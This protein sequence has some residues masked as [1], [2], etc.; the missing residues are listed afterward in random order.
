M[1]NTQSGLDS[2]PLSAPLHLRISKKKKHYMVAKRFNRNVF[3]AHIFREIKLVSYK[4]GKSPSGWTRYVVAVLPSFPFH[5]SDPLPSTPRKRKRYAKSAYG[6]REEERACVR[7]SASTCVDRASLRANADETCVDAD[8]LL[9]F[10][11][12]F[13]LLCGRSDQTTPKS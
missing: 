12:F 8:T 1:H 6:E 3:M 11:L 7:Q 5:S 4:I 10:I 2:I 13:A 9:N